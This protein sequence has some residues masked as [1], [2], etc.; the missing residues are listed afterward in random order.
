MVKAMNR[1]QKAQ[2]T[3]FLQNQE[4][5]L[6]VAQHS[7]RKTSR[8]HAHCP[9]CEDNHRRMGEKRYAMEQPLGKI[10]SGT[11][12][13]YYRMLCLH[14][15]CQ[16]QWIQSREREQ[17]TVHTK[18]RRPAYKPKARGGT[19]LRFRTNTPKCKSCGSTTSVLGG[20]GSKLMNGEVVNV[21]RFRCRD[22]KCKTITTQIDR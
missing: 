4:H 15:A 19:I 20:A 22:P 2:L 10:L 5:A 1:S 18:V 12:P 11:S 14:R 9:K 17:V 13:G 8:V 6:V 21:T 3:T 16:N 7:R